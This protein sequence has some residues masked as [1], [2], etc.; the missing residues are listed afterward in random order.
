MPDLTTIVE[1]FG[2]ELA[3]EILKELFD[4]EAEDYAA[5][6]TGEEY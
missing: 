2:E 1:L 6:M 5:E 3:Q 4:D